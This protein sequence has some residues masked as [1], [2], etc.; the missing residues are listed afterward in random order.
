MKENKIKISE[1][2]SLTE[3]KEL[4][5]SLKLYK[6]LGDK[7]WNRWKILFKSISNDKNI[8]KIEYFEGM[9]KETA[10]KEWLKAYKQIFWKE[11]KEKNIIL[12]SKESLEG[13]IRIYKNDS[14]VDLSFKKVSD[15]LK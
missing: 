5:N 1:D 9:K 2:L 8:Y 6:D 12:I 3:L 7:L 15:A 13:G 11:P 10:L 14:L 4:L